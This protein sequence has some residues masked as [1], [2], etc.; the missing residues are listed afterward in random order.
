PAQNLIEMIQVQFD[1]GFMPN[2]V[3][4]TEIPI[5]IAE[6][7][8]FVIDFSQF[9]PGTSLILQ[10]NDS[11]SGQCVPH[12]C[13]AA[14]SEIMRFDVVA[15]D[16]DDGPD[17]TVV[18]GTALRNVP[19]NDSTSQF[20]IGDEIKSRAFRFTSEGQPFWTMV[21]EDTDD[22]DGDRTDR[23]MDCRRYDVDPFVNTVEKW[24]LHGVGNWTHSI[25]IHDVDQVCVS[26]NGSTTGSGCETF[27]KFKETWPMAPGVTFEVKIKPTDF[28]QQSAEN[29]NAVGD[30]SDPSD[31]CR[32]LNGFAGTSGNCSEN[33]FAGTSGVDTVPVA[34]PLYHGDD[35]TPAVSDG[36]SLANAIDGDAA[37][38]RYMFH[39][40]VLEH[41]DTGMMTHWRVRS[42]TPAAPTNVRNDFPCGSTGTPGTTSE[43][44]PTSDNIETDV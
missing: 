29:N 10:N 32:R 37:G 43:C 11:A 14:T 1:G 16:T 42:G 22:I 30:A 3:A 19:N 6:K 35:P 31:P 27:N 17:A 12:S 44:S 15:I 18:N 34:E 28:T 26:I 21:R 41:E 33:I 39:C 38:G 7:L 2:A 40:H 36:E 5:G 8:S 23:I 4:R 25:H 24:T 13:S 20:Y 9:S